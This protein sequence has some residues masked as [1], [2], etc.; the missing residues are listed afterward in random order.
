MEEPRVKFEFKIEYS[1]EYKGLCFG[2]LKLEHFSADCQERLKCKECKKSHP[3][4]L[5]GAKSSKHCT[6]NINI[7][8]SNQQSAKS[9]KQLEAI[10]THNE[11]A[12]AHFTVRRSLDT[13]S[14]IATSIIIPV[15]VHHK[16]NLDNKVKTYPLLDDEGDNTFITDNLLGAINVKG[17]DVSLQLNTMQG[18]E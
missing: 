6:Q 15:T 3:T 14:D 13:H 9:M 8:S 18:R 2:S 4:L 7:A 16:D 11:S 17:T 12:N 1:K 10:F 5:H